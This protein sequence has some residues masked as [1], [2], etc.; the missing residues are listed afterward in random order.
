MK[1]NDTHNSSHQSLH[2]APPHRPLTSPGP[3]PLSTRRRQLLALAL[4]SPGLAAAHGNSLAPAK[5]AAAPVQTAWGVAGDAR[6]DKPRTVS[7]RMTDAMRFT[8]AALQVKLG[9]TLRFL[10]RNEGKM[11]HEFVIGTPEALEEHAALMLKFP[12]MEHDEPYMAHVPPGQTGEI[13][14][15]FNRPGRFRYACLIAGHYQAGMV[16]DITVAG[17]ATPPQ[18]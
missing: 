1:T 12:D 2:Q 7:I 13:V 6:R 14:W 11:L 18:R 16:G 17:P 3:G 4:A 15:T 9:E 10:V 5:P 8:P